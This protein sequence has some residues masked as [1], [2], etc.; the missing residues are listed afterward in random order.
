MSGDDSTEMYRRVT[1][2]LL[3]DEDVD[4]DVTPDG[5]LVHGRLFAFLDGLELVVKVPEQR[6]A[7][8]LSRG[9]VSAFDGGGHLSR[10]WVRVGDLQLWS[11]LAREA[12]ESVAKPPVGHES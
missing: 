4:V 1:V 9:V 12:H 5:L 8:L 2:E 7:D 11:E 3:A 6:A 10:D